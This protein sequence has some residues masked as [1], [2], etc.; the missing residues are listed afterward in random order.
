MLGVQA[1]CPVRSLVPALGAEE[2]TLFFLRVMPCATRPAAT[3]EV[4]HVDDRRPRSSTS[5]HWRAMLEPMS[6]LVLVVGA[7]DTS[8]GT[9]VD[10]PARSPRRPVFAARSP[11]LGPPGRRTG[12]TGR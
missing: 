1:D 9:R 10:L 2:D 4:G 8:I 7:D 6:G 3:E 5:Y 11:S 12:R